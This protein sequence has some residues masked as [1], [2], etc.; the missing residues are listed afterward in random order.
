MNIGIY[1]GSGNQTTINAVEV[2]VISKTKK[3]TQESFE[4]QGHVDCFLWYPVYCDGRVQ[5]PDGKSAVLH[6][7]LEEFAWQREKE[8]SGV[9]E[10]PV[11]F[12][13]GQR[14]SPQ[15]IVCEAIFSY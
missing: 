14:A 7:S 2:N 6:W 10:K 5:W 12:A 9:M 4:F 3:I 15:R 1:V 13:P 8:T 11:D